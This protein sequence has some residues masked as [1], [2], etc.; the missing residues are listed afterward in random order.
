M[1]STRSRASRRFVATGAVL[2]LLVSLVVGLAGPGVGPASAAIGS[3][4]TGANSQQGA[5]TDAGLAANCLK[6]YGIALGKKDGTFGEDDPLK[7]SQF[8]SFA[9]R[10][11]PQVVTVN[12]RR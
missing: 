7:R 5:F 3:A 9:T 10:F 1:S 11:R 4:C 12:S 2:G 6:A 8:A